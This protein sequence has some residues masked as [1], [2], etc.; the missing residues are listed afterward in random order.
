MT[1]SLDNENYGGRRKLP[2][3]FTGQGIAMLSG[4]LKN[5]TAVEIS[6][7]IIDAFVSMRRFISSNKEVFKRLTNVEYKLL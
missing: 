1:S 3:I 4:L 5:E 2:Y 7:N 6:I